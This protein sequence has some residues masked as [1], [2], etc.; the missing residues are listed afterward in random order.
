VLAHDQAP[1]RVEG[2]PVALV[3]RAGD[4]LDAA[5]LVPPAPGVGRHVGKQQELAVRVPDRALREREPRPELLDLGV[6]VDEVV[7]P[8]VLGDD[9]HSR[10]SL[11]SGRREARRT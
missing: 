6:L 7:D 2:H 8:V 3:A 10:A 4:D 5:A 9:A 1:V 11:S